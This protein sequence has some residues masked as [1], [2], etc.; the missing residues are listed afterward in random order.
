MFSQSQ[1]VNST[2]GQKIASLVLSQPDNST[3]ADNSTASFVLNASGAD[4]TQIY[5]VAAPPDL[6]NSTASNTTA[7]NSTAADGLSPAS[8]VKVLLQL[9]VFDPEHAMMK[10]YCA[11]F[12]P[13]PPAPSPLMVE[14]CMNDTQGDEHKSQVFAY[15][16]DTGVIRPM[17]FNGEDDGTDDS[18]PADSSDDP[19]SSS[20]STTVDPTTPSSDKV[21]N[22][23]SLDEMALDKQFGDATRP[24]LHAG[25]AKE[26][27]ADPG[28]ARNVTLVF[29]PAAPEIMPQK[30]VDNDSD[31]DSTSD[32][33][34]STSSSATATVSASATS[35]DSVSAASDMATATATSSSTDLETASASA[36][37]LAAKFESTT[38]TTT[39]DS[40]TASATSSA[41]SASLAVE[42][43]NPGASSSASTDSTASTASAS[44][45][46]S[47]G[48]QDMEATSS[49]TPTDTATESLSGASSTMTP[50]STAPY[51]W[52]FREGTV[53][54][55]RS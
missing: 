16:P 12:D 43:Y 20:N 47:I 19:T 34:T 5:L 4:Q 48:A 23:T 15:E 46:D 3:A 54:A 8:F 9:P 33:D 39:S 31:S 44:P 6:S 45:S 30:T 1:V 37:P 42:V 38:V 22:V 24:P 7:S 17:W 13:N 35:S 36:T 50:V 28:F 10:A 26:F 51:E 18:D 21:V 2:V 49:I 14:M 32:A 29:T 11:T 53:K 52:M 55:T 25:L 41:T 27:D 40:A